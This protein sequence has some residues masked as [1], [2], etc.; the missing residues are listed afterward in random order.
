MVYCPMWVADMD[1]RCAQEIVDVLKARAEHPV[2]GYTYQRESGVEAMLDFYR[3]H[4]G[5]QLEKDEQATIPCVVTGMKA[6]ILSLT[7]PGDSILIQPPV[8]GPFFH[9]RTG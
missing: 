6:A 4:N 9:L 1:I 2:Y 3:R 8:Y 5:L 7:E